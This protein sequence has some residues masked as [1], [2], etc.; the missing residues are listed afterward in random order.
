MDW[1]EWGYYGLFLASFLSA[2]VLPGS[3]EAILV[4]LLVGGADPIISVATATTGNTLGGMS[5]YGIGYLGKW[6]WLDKYFGVKQ[7]KVEEWKPRIDRFGSISAIFSFVPVIG[8]AI[9]VALGFF[10]ANLLLTTFWMVLGK[11]GRYV[12]VT[13]LTL[14]F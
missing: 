9:P 10:R 3:S 5:S 8:D 1:I 14:Q 7:E 4:A 11:L 6:E 13:W 2:T 12:V